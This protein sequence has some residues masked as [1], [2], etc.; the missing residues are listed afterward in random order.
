MDAEKAE[1]RERK[2]RAGNITAG[3]MMLTVGVLFLTGQLG[4]ASI[5]DLWH[6]WPLALI[7][8]GITH[9]VIGQDGEGWVSGITNVFLGV[10]F[11][12]IN[13]QWFGFG[14]RTGWPLVL[15]AIGASL[16]LKAAFGV[17]RRRRF[18]EESGAVVVE[19]ERHV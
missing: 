13:F 8:I 15:I 9:M 2:D 18:R 11:L 10:A 12:A 14:W 1:R 5:H 19:D 17:P 16:M 7:A 3:L 6:W 4:L